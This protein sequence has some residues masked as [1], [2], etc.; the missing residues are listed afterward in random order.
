M[1]VIGGLIVFAAIAVVL[2]WVFMSYQMASVAVVTETANPIDAIGMALRRGFARGIRWR[3]VL[4]GLV[5]FIVSQAG[6][7][8][9]LGVAAALTMLTHIN[10]LY[11]AISG[12]GSVL[13]EAIIAAFVVVFAVDIRVR[14][15][16]F[17][18]IAAEPPPVLP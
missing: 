16:G 1:G 18:I 13:I 3:M 9:L 8:P 5:V 17:D 15:E 2:S 10:L 4:G 6:S 11:F 14:R 12:V 7:W